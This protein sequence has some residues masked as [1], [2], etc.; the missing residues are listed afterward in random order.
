MNTCWIKNNIVQYLWN[1]LLRMSLSSLCVKN[2][3]HPLYYILLVFRLVEISLVLDTNNVLAVH[4]TGLLSLCPLT[5]R[6]WISCRVQRVGVV[7]QPVVW[8]PVWAHCCVVFLTSL[9]FIIYYKLSVRESKQIHFEQ[10]QWFHA[11]SWWHNYIDNDHLY[12]G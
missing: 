5:A 4:P 8:W 7:L 2:Q 1:I 9:L 3:I 12:L 11:K 6:F 10:Y